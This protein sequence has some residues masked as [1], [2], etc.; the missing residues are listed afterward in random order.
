MKK[1]K[2]Y[3]LM[4]L[5]LG[6]F[7]VLV[8]I[9]ILAVE[10][11]NFS[12]NGGIAIIGGADLPETLQITLRIISSDFWFTII[13]GLTIVVCAAFCLIF[14]KTVM[15]NC[16][17]K[18]TAVSLGI[19]FA[20]ASGLYCFFQW[21]SIVVFHEM[22]RHPIRFP[23]SRIIGL[24]SFAAFVFLIV[25]YCRLRKQSFS[26]KGILIDIATCLIAFLPFQIIITIVSNF[27]SHVHL[28]F[29]K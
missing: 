25:L 18:T 12:Q 29:Y 20:G 1:I 4:V 16:T 17:M 21:Y 7:L 22:S 8:S 26:I 11:N 28:G 27:V 3:S 24:L 15:N 5:G 13:I 10:F 19:S 6:L 14:S 23:A 2:T 9:L